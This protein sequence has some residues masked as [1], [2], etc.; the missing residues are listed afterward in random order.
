MTTVRG[1]EF[2][3]D[4]FYMVEHDI[5]AR[6]ES[7]G[8]LTVGLT[9]LGCRVSGEFIEFMPKPV[10]TAVERDRALA[11]LEM[12]KTIRSARAP[13]AG[14]IVAVN[15][16][17]RRQPQLLNH[18][19]YG[20]GWLVRLRADNWARDAAALTRGAAVAPAVERYMDLYLVPEFGDD[21]G[22]RR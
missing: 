4:L 18:D 15:D 10:G 17:V 14:T 3:D 21:D 12:S 2:P 5:W 19:P 22:L 20:G 13:A 11:V 1:Y 6:C 9:A 8:T 7:D 16:E